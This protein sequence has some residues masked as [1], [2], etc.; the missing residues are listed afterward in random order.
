MVA[1]TAAA[2][3]DRLVAARVCQ[4]PGAEAVAELGLP[5]WVPGPDRWQLRTIRASIPEL[6]GYTLQGVWR[7]CRRAGIRLRQA[8]PR[9]YSPD[10]EYTTK[11]TTLLTLL[12]TMATDP[13][14]IVVLFL[15]EMG[16]QRWPQPAPS[17]APQA[18]TPPPTTQPD[19]KE[20]KHRIA[21]MLD[22]YSGRVLRV[23]GNRVG[24]DRLVQL[25]RQLDAAYPIATHIH[26]IQDNW[27]VHDHETIRAALATM[28]RISRVWLPIAAWWLNPI[29]KLWRKLRQEVL[30][31]HRL[32]ED[33]ADIHATVRDYLAGFADAS[34]ALLDAVGLLGDG[35]LARARRGEPL[36]DLD[37]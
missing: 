15:D 13:E 22:A 4:P 34:P 24:A 12:Q 35:P 36:T 19:G 30:R 17:F 8:R 14:H 23:D 9:L 6:H 16:Y 18:P 32:A 33:W 1:L 37:C 25:Y 11:R 29:E 20:A 26:V 21:G 10:P 3:V 28:P 2:F 7:A 31:L 27:P 5:D